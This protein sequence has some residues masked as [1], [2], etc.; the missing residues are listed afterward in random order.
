MAR[1]F[2]K[3]NE[4]FLV[5]FSFAKGQRDF[6]RSIAEALENKLGRGTVFLR[7]LVRLLSRRT[8]YRY[9]VT[10]NLFGASEL[11]IPCISEQYGA[12]FH[13]KAEHRAIRALGNK[14]PNRF[15]PLR[16]GD[17]EIPGIRLQDFYCADVRN[18]EPSEVTDLIVARLRLIDPALVREAIPADYVETKEPLPLSGTSVSLVKQSDQ[19][20]KVAAPAIKASSIATEPSTDSDSSS[21]LLAIEKV[22]AGLKEKEL[23][24]E[25]ALNKSGLLLTPPP[26]S[27]AWKLE[28]NTRS[29]KVCF[30]S[31]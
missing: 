7:R 24:V 17:G 29:V 21:L 2:P 27:E 19:G 31:Q 4:K 20:S 18:L 25:F 13:T 23:V 10:E 6:V 12:Q 14:D 15:L 8:R 5:A 9:Q 30:F 28:R 11:V 3:N 26:L 22:Q 16:M 1:S